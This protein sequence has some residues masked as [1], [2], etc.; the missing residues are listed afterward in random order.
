[1]RGHEHVIKTRIQGRK[2]AYSVTLSTLP[3]PVIPNDFIQLEASD[4]PETA[5]LRFVI[6]LGVI[7]WGDESRFVRQW[8]EA[9]HKAG[10]AH[11]AGNVFDSKGRSVDA[12]IIFANG[13]TVE[14]EQ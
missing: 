1:M 13:Q 8:C 7:V 6:G 2:P 9:A 5:D 10:A 4:K 14:L 11:A 12:F 3:V